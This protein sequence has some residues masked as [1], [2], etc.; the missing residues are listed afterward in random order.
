MRTGTLHLS[1]NG[2]NNWEVCPLS[3]KRVESSP[4]MTAYDLRLPLQAREYSCLGMD[5]L[6]SL[7]YFQISGRSFQ[8]ASAWGLINHDWYCCGSR[9]HESLHK[10]LKGSRGVGIPL[11]Y[12]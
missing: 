5:P 4:S 1:R 12:V 2:L 9:H 3:G 11:K 8:S 7:I 6:I 10:A